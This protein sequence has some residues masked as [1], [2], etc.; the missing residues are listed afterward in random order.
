MAR[1]NAKLTALSVRARAVFSQRFTQDHAYSMGF[2][3]GL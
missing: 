2:K 1:R 3:S